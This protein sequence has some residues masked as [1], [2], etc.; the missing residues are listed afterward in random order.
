MKQT[1]ELLLFWTITVIFPILTCFCCGRD[2]WFTELEDPIAYRVPPRRVLFYEKV[3]DWFERA[4]SSPSG[5]HGGGFIVRS[6]TRKAIAN[7][8]HYSNDDRLIV[9]YMIGQEET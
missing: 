6:T 7:H 9:R 3:F 1:I 4:S 2:T 8:M 5:S